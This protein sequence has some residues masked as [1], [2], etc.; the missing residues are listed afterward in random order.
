MQCTGLPRGGVVTPLVSSGGRLAALLSVGNAPRAAG[1]N[2]VTVRVPDGISPGPAVPLRVTS[3]DRPTNEVT[4][5]VRQH[6]KH[7]A[8][9]V[10]S[11]IVMPVRYFLRKESTMRYLRMTLLAAFA[12]GLL[13]LPAGIHLRASDADA[14]QQMKD[15]AEIEALMWRYVRALDNQDADAYVSLYT[16]DGEFRAGPNPTKGT[17]ALKK[18]VADIKNGRVEREKAGE[19]PAPMYHVITND[20]LEF[21]GKDQARYHSYWMTVFGA[22]G[23]GGQPRVA[24]AG[25]GVDLLVKVNSKWLIKSRNVAPGDAD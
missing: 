18:M 23:R 16:P 17:A 25:H 5:A 7:R 1:V 19:M 22:V 12:A 20:Y 4:L 2:Q 15:R 3:L 10:W 8:R 9:E 24:A 14:V 21:V 11:C 6:R 13:I